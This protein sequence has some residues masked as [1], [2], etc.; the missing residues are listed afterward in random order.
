MEATMTEALV[1]HALRYAKRGIPVFPLKPRGKLPLTV[2]GFKDAT[3]DERQIRAW[4]D[5]WS[6]ANIGIPTG[7]GTF[8]VVDVDAKSGGHESLAHLIGAFGEIP[9]TPLSLTGGGGFHYC[10]QPAAGFRNS[11]GRLGQGIDTRGDGGYIV[12]PPS[13]H[14]SGRPYSWEGDH[15]F[16]ELSLAPL[17]DWLHPERAKPLPKLAAGNLGEVFTPGPP[18]AD[19]SPVK[20]GGRN[21]AA[22]SLAG[23]YIT[24]GM[25]LHE[26]MRYLSEW[27]QTNQPPLGDDE[28][29]RT[30][31]SVART[32][33]NNHPAAAIPV[34]PPPAELS[35]GDAQPVDII[36]QLVKPKTFPPHL[37]TP[38]GFVGRLCQ[39]MN[40]TAIKPQPVL[41]M[42]NAMAFWGA[43]IG[44]KVATR[45]DLRS[46]LY[47]LGVGE[48]GS[49][50]DHSRKCI[51]RLCAR[52]GL[53]EYILGGE[54]ISSDSAIYKAVY[55]HPSVL[56][57]FDE[58]GH[59]L[60][61][62]NSK[63]AASHQRAIAPLLTKLFS[64]AQT[65]FLGKEYA[66][67]KDN[68]RQDIEQPNVCIYGTTVPDRLYE[69]LSPGEI[70]D[71][72]LGRMIV[73]QSN[74]PD[75]EEQEVLS[76][77][78]PEDV[79][80]SVQA[81]WQRDDIPKADGNI[82]ATRDV[83]QLLVPMEPEAEQLFKEFRSR[84]RKYKADNR[85]GM[86]LDALWARAVE[87][88]IKVSLVIACGENFTPII[89]AATAAWSI[90]L[91]EHTT[92]SLI[93][94]VQ[95]SV[96]GSDYERNLLYVFRRIQDAGE[97]GLTKTQLLQQTRRLTT[98]ERQAILD[99]LVEASYITLDKGKNVKGF[100]AMLY[101]VR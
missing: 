7:A 10:F 72:F 93:D 46:N 87:H 101:R 90:E 28:L 77:A 14:E 39:W 40:E 57:Q 49:G 96:A 51:K 19:G 92:Q 81:W 73:L 37:L 68:R 13:V 63:Y 21:N 47:I 9:E 2:R 53:T 32:H 59:M 8:S 5:R 38:P 97:A 18:K 56:F 45:T 22:A 70:K 64:S 84:C 48:S 44:R 71:G 43:V 36:A 85:R 52:A 41:A 24:K 83:L 26:V 34:A 61:N 54:D 74:D 31:A 80:T 20:E 23:Q 42:G 50:K 30:V 35:T 95:F 94:V 17:P 91:I 27:N 75:P 82:A 98:R 60:A 86:A 16:F 55:E 25:S 66:N 100:A 99:H 76:T 4:W 67:R 29:A 69:G 65:T 1:D 3:T 88:A 6:D 11:A 33:A 79:V 89:S 62:A 58:I 12:A 78:V 15:D